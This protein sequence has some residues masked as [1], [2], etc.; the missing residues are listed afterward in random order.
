MDIDIEVTGGTIYALPVPSITADTVIIG[1]NVYLRGWSLRDARAD[2]PA[3]ASGNTTAPAAGATVA[4]TG[5]L[6]AGTYTVAWTVGLQGAAAAADANNFELVD[7][8]GVVLVSVNPGAAGEFPQPNVEVT[9]AQSTAISVKAVGA[10][11][12]AIVYSAEISV[13]PTGDFETVIEIQD[14]T[15]PISEVSFLNRKTET[16][17][18]GS[19]GICIETG[20]NIHV[21]SGAV[22]G[23]LLVAYDKP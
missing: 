16:Q 11:T 4:T 6:P 7:S 17:A 22:T 23:S 5:N 14:G 20:L 2:L 18:F 8:N 3:Q 13:T 12:A 1:G 10:G 9:I 15:K 21:I 19:P